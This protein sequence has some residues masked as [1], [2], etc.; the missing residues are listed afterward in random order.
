MKRFILFLGLLATCIAASAGD[1]I[2]A[3][4]AKELA[5]E[6]FS[7]TNATAK[8]A[9]TQT[10]NYVKSSPA[11]AWHIFNR[12]GGGFVIVS[13]DS[14]IGPYLAYSDEGEFRL[15]ERF[16]NVTSYLSLLEDEVLWYRN[17]PEASPCI[18]AAPTADG[19]VNL[20]TALWDQGSPYNLKCPH[21]SVTGCVA[22]AMAIVMKYNRWPEKG[23][24][25]L[26][27]YTTTTERYRVEGYPLGHTYEWD[28]MPDNGRFTTQEQKE[29]ISQLMLDCG[30]MVYMDYTPRGSGAYTD[31][32]L[33]AMEEHMGYDD[34]MRY[35][36]RDSYSS[37]QWFKIIK[38]QID[39]NHPIL[40][41]GVSRDGGHQFVVDGYNA[42]G[43]VHVNFGW[44]GSDN[45]FYT[46]A[47]MGGF[48]TGQ[49]MVINVFKD[50]GIPAE[51][52][53]V[54]THEG[55]SMVGEYKKGESFDVKVRNVANYGEKRINLSIAVGLDDKEGN[56]S[57][58]ISNV[59]TGSLYPYYYWEETTLTCNPS[60]R[61]RSGRR[62]RIYYKTDKVTEW[63]PVEYNEDVTTGEIYPAGMEL[64]FEKE[65]AI[66]Y[67]KQSATITISL[68]SD[69]MEWSFKDA[70]GKEIPVSASD[71]RMTL[72]ISTSGISGDC[73]L[74]LIH[75]DRVKSIILAL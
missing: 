63:T 42:A 64:I 33:P 14:A 44:S 70:S 11:Q 31:D 9:T 32:I 54:V 36:Y 30:V 7:A 57:E 58:I 34:S 13:G 55:I 61:I 2:S 69:E 18:D 10:L 53:V 52:L 40:Y 5:A 75:E 41:G 3:E 47:N 28:L 43:K 38:G 49:D 73:T 35:I 15:D 16:T 8:T 74:T 71:D 26:S 72:E 20:N 1:L 39:A 12:N 24:G 19:D 46:I 50:D 66:S 62:I 48:T 4:K 21:N 29:Q 67:D 65:T 22:T 27:S 68:P 60:Q 51:D 45:G 56:L 25:T 17:H 6:F 59:E 23:T 37:D